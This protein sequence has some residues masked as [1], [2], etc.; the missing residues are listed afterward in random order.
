M[1]TSAR[2]ITEQKEEILYRDKINEKAKSLAE[3]FVVQ[4]RNARVALK[5]KERAL[6][7]MRSTLNDYK[8]KHDLL[9][10]NPDKEAELDA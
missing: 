5:E 9:S 10:A 1:F 3:T 4:L 7:E 8:L 6:A 2:T